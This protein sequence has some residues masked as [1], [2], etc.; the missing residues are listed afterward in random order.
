MYSV[1]TGSNNRGEPVINHDNDQIELEANSK[2]IYK[3]PAFIKE[4]VALVVL[5]FHFLVLELQIQVSRFQRF[6]LLQHLKKS[7]RKRLIL[8]K[9]APPIFSFALHYLDLLS[10]ADPK[11]GKS[12][13]AVEGANGGAIICN[14]DL[15]AEP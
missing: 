6:L 10:E 11:T 9:I 2:A 1:Y 14:E 3:M 13:W 7:R 5:A 8:L 4:A 15:I 12:E